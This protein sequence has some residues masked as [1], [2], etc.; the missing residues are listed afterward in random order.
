MLVKIMVMISG[1]MTMRIAFM[2]IAPIGAEP[3][4]NASSHA[5]PVAEA[6]RPTARPSTRPAAIARCSIQ[7]LLCCGVQS[8]QG[9][10][11]NAG[12]FERRRFSLARFVSVSC[13][14]THR[15]FHRR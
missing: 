5:L 15:F 9:A 2:K 11:H 6:P 7:Y 13:Q 10:D 14:G 8:V 3:S 1:M 4:A 12:E